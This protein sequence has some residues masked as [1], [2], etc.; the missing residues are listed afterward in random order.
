[1]ARIKIKDLPRDTKIS[2]EDM[3]SI[4]GGNVTVHAIM[5]DLLDSLKSGPGMDVCLTPGKTGPPE[6]VPEP[7]TDSYPVG[8]KTVKSEPTKK[9]KQP[10]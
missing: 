5:G 4:I 6:P 1:M 2:K 8:T 10:L 7:G 3:K 9:Y